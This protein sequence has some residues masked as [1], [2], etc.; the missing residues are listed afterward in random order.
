MVFLQILEW[1]K[2]SRE[3]INNTTMNLNQIRLSMA[4][5]I[6]LLSSCSSV[7]IVKELR[8]PILN[9]AFAG[10]L[11]H[12]KKFTKQTHALL[13]ARN[14]LQDARDKPAEVVIVLQRSLGDDPSLQVRLALVEVCSDEGDSLAASEPMRAVGYHLAAAEAA[15]PGALK[16]RDA[17]KRDEL[18]ELYNFS[19]GRVADILFENG[20]D[21]SKV[22]E[23]EGPGQ[24]YQLRCKT[25]G[26]GL[27]SPSYFDQFW[28]ARNLEIKGLDRLK[29]TTRTGFGE[30]M[31]G[32]R[33]FREERKKNE[34]LL[35]ASGL[36]IPVTV[37][38]APA[39]K[40]GVM[41]MSVY[42]DLIANEAQLEGETVALS[43][44]FTAPLAVL[45][46]YKQKGN[47]G[48]KGFLHP[49]R[50][51]EKMGIIQFEPFR[52]GQIPV[53]FVHGL[54]SSPATW[55]SAVNILRK[56]PVLRGKYQLLAFYYP[57]GFPIAYNAQGL[58]N[59]LKAF[60]EF[61]NPNGN[62]PNMKN[63]IIVGHSMG[64]LLSN[65]QIRHSGDT[66]SKRVFTV[67]IDE[68][69]GLDEGQ[70]KMAKDRLIYRAN[71]NI[72]RA[73]F[74][75]SPHRGSEIATGGIGSLAKKLIKFPIEFVTGGITFGEGLE[76]GDLTEFGQEV[77]NRGNSSINSLEPNGV[78]VTGILEQKVRQGVEFHSI[79]AQ[80]DFQVPIT[81]GS[82]KVV[83]YSSAHLDAARSEKVVHATH[84]TIN[85]NP[86][87]VE[88]LRRILYLHAG[89]DYT[90]TPDDM[91]YA[92]KPAK[93]AKRKVTSYG[94]NK[95]K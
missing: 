64:G 39:G 34:P 81:E 74:V 22:I 46:N 30:M 67:P 20:H 37:V 11:L 5:A 77:V 59:H 52:S 28:A 6:L 35:G 57:T 65:T 3:Q 18:R 32:H 1:A 33:D 88:E 79:I 85:A 92:A 26:K 21:W 17:G 70:K 56:D 31:V 71:P 13:E 86:D 4:L 10:E 12:P 14:L 40:N 2:V 87:A 9:S 91:L 73:V 15:L 72:T 63:L 55:G 41:E 75:A 90:R 76:V 89:L 61:Y 82:D 69:T 16:G 27:V 49:D 50:Y 47:V 84:T 44:D 23:V 66:L 42:D 62:N 36:S 58:R 94:T 7:P 38:I 78:M 43:A 80:S 51:A 8:V 45:Y 24:N 95:R 53:I 60:Q 54:A 19:C 68:V 29:R 93:A 83:S 48:A 25:S